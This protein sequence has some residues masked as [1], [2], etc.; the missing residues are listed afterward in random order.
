MLV[1]IILLSS[2]EIRPVKLLPLYGV[3][4][5]VENIFDSVKMS[6]QSC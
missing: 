4:D 5:T 2:E 1:V 6:Y 3:R